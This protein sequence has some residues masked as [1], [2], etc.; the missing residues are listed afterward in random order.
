MYLLNFVVV[1]VNSP[2]I[3]GRKSCEELNVVKRIMSVQASSNNEIFIGF[4]DVF[5]GIGCLPGDYKI[6]LKEG[7]R[8][9][10]H[11]P[12][13]LPIA[14]RDQVKS[15]LKDMIDQGIIAKVEGPTD[16]VNSMTVAKKADG[17]IRIC[18][19]P[20]DL[21]NAIKRE[22][23]KLPTLEEITV[24]LKGAKYFSTLDAKQGFW[25]V[26]LNKESTDLCT[27]NTVFGRYKFLRMPYGIS[28]ASEIFHKKLYEHFDDIEGVTLFVDDLLI[29]AETKEKHDFILKRVLQRCREINIKLNKNKCKIGL[30]EIEYLGHKITKNGIY[31]DDSHLTAIKNM[32]RPTNKKD[33]ERFLGRITYVGNFIP[34]LSEKTH[35]LRQLL[36]NDV[37][38][39]W[40]QNHE[41]SFQK[42]KESLTRPPVLRYYDVNKPVTL[43]VDSS[44]TGIGVCL[45]QEG[46]PVCYASKSL[47]KTEQSYAQIEKELY[48]VVFACEKFYMY[49]YGRS[50][51]LNGRNR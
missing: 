33:I 47:T 27:F 14:I 38:W 35:D 25:Q 7:A 12:R 28:S 45:L 43:S 24:N 34:N 36:K 50:D 10:V 41:I 6:Q 26:Q 16:W 46:M 32:P 51:I 44:K 1:D 8:P 18:L 9:V 30:S 21:N 42:L 3:L 15:K 37:E 11:A 4:Q 39:H 13:K 23:F 2:P 22:H 19:D 49:L 29:Y 20:K 5:E 40:E 31:P 48:A 17:D